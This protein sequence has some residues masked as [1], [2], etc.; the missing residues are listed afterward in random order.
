MSL[1]HFDE[2]SGIVAA[3]TPWG[4]WWQTVSEVFIEINIPPDTPG[5]DCKISIKPKYLECRIKDKDYIK[6]RH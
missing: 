3:E 2:R 4:R 6:V 5:K 1:S